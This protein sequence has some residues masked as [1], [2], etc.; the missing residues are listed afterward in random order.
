VQS[1]NSFVAGILVVTLGALLPRVACTQERIE[2]DD[3]EPTIAFFAPADG[4]YIEYRE[5]SFSV[6]RP[7]VI[8]DPVVLG[9]AEAYPDN[10]TVEQIGPD[11]VKVRIT[12]RVYDFLA[13]MVA[14]GEADIEEIVITSNYYG[15]LSPIPVTR[16]SA[17]YAHPYFD[18]A[19][20]NINRALRPFPFS[21]RFDT[22][23][24]KLKIQSGSN[25]IN[26][27]ATNTDTNTGTAVL[28]IRASVNREEEKYDIDVSV[29]DAMDDGL[30]VPILVHI[31]DDDVTPDNVNSAYAH[32]NGKRV[33]LR[34]IDGQLQLDRP[35]IGVGRST[36]P[37]AVPNVVNVVGDDDRFRIRYKDEEAVFTWGYTSSP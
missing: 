31:N 34:F 37:D 1:R 23:V 32:L 10:T 20:L 9:S 5:S 30:Y 33:G 24:Q 2:S 35:I 13:D 25:N 8:L 14:G 26:A 16:Q 7:I 36:Q 21:G 4:R 27:T 11:E 6:P 22:G 3:S 19:S 15:S 12:G 17:E 28:M 18:A 29:R